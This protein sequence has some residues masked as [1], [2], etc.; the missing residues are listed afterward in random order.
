MN[1]RINIIHLY[2]L[3][4][5]LHFELY[6]IVVLCIVLFGRERKW[7]RTGVV[8]KMAA[9]LIYTA[10][11]ALKMC[12]RHDYKQLSC[13]CKT[14]KKFICIS[15]AQTSHH[16]HDWDLIATVAKECRMETPKLCR[17][18]QKINLPECREK[19]RSI[20]NALQNRRKGCMDKLE[21][22]RTLLISLVNRVVD[23]QKKMRDELARNEKITERMCRDLECKLDYVDKLTLSLDGNIASYSDYDV[24]E[25]VHEMLVTLGEVER[26]DANLDASVVKY[27]PGEIN[28]GLLKEMIGK[29]EESTTT[30]I[31]EIE[32]VVEMKAFEV[33]DDSIFTIAPISESQ[34]WVDNRIKNDMTL[35]SVNNDETKHMAFSSYSDFIA[36]SNGQLIVTSPQ[37]QTIRRVSQKGKE[38]V[39][40]T[41]KPLLPIFVS[42]THTDDILV[43][44]RD[45][46]DDFKLKPSS[47]R[48]VQRMT[49]KGKVTHA[50]EFREDGTTRLLNSPERTAENGNS[51]I[52]VI[53]RTGHAT[54]E[55]VVL[56]EDGSVRFIYRGQDDIEFAPTDVAC[57]DMS[58]IIVSYPKKLFLYL[59]NQHGAFLG[60][61]YLLP[62]ISDYLCKI[63]LEQGSLWVGFHDGTLKVYKYTK[64]VAM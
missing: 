22:R 45:G 3:S 55:L 64:S 21:Q 53:N 38:R 56:H 49:L 30:N 5:Y 20:D 17:K 26:Y 15:C 61:M 4:L 50:Y 27:V 11:E 34:A 28:T 47:R 36:L 8:R 51:D 32:R 6:V 59:L 14:C 44:L 60:N 35:L 63:A 23:E 24:I 46:G 54:G 62:D 58:R 48:L 12:S 25:K 41:T 40:A 16:G 43:T 13:F 57:D 39:F 33:F 37:K 7:P 42:K 52:C 18:I 2:L 9:S 31:E 10:Q 29:I 1:K 19:I